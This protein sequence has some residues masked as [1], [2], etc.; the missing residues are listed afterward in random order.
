MST[1]GPFCSRSIGENKLKRKERMA[2][3]F[4]MRND[5]IKAAKRLCDSLQNN[6]DFEMYLLGHQHYDKAMNL[7]STDVNSFQNSNSP[8]KAEGIQDGN[9]SSREA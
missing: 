8:N 2:D 7:F 5:K 4:F 9:G 1:D 3:N 6:D